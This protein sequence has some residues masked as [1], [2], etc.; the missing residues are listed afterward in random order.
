V[1]LVAGIFEMPFWR[2][3]FANFTSAFVWAGVLLLLGDVVA[4]VIKWVWGG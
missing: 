2:F 1:P 3:Q 4:E